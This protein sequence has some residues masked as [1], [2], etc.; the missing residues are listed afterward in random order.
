MKNTRDTGV[1]I[2]YEWQ[3]NYIDLLSDPQDKRNNVQFFTEE[4][5]HEQSF[6]KWLRTFR[7]DIHEE[8]NRRLRVRRNELR[9]RA[10]KKLEDQ[11][12]SD[13]GGN[14]IKALELYFKLNGDLIERTENRTEMISPEQKK[15][16][17]A[18]FLQEIQDKTRGSDAEARQE[19]DGCTTGGEGGLNSPV[20]GEGNQPRTDLPSGGV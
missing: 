1:M 17:L 18:Q 4:K 19:G 9:L 10:W 8:A 12:D 5:V 2:K 15:V 20:S 3:N 16:R 13:S 11:F 14:V 7:Q 6:Y